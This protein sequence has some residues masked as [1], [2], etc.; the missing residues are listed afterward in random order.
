MAADHRVQI[1]T[2]A[3]GDENTSGDDKVDLDLLKEIADTTGGRSW[4]AA[5][6]GAALDEVWKEIDALTPV[7][8]KTLGWSWHQPLY[9][10]PLGLALLLLLAFTLLDYRKESATHE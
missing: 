9:P 1:H 8:V 2:I 4:Q 6:S 10:W 3:F 5:R 7:E